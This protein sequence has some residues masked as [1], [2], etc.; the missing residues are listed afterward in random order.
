MDCRRWD[1]NAGVNEDSESNCYVNENAGVNRNFVW[2]RKILSH[3]FL[4]SFGSQ[5]WDSGFALQALVASNLA[6]EIPDVLRK[7][8]DFFKNSQVRYPLQYYFVTLNDQNK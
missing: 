1:E 2:H 8:H 5:L 3:V 4:Q 7:G 6:N